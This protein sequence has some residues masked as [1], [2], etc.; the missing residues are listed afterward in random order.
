M[1][2]NT[3]ITELTRVGKTVASRLKRLEIET[4]KDLLFHFPFRYE[5]YS[6]VVPIKELEEGKDVT[7]QGTI[8]MINSRRAHRRRMTITEAIVADETGELRIVWF[9]Q[10]FIKKSLASGNTVSLSGKIKRD[11]LGMQ[12]SAPT[13]E[14]LGK[15]EPTYTGKLLPIYPTTSSITQKQLRFLYKQ[16]EPVIDSLEEWIPERVLNDVAIPSLKEALRLIHYPVSVAKAETGFE[17]MKFAELFLL[18]L[19]VQRVR[20]LMESSAST[21]IPFDE[22]AVKSFVDSLPF[23]LTKDQKVAAWQIIQDMQGEH[24]MNRLVQG[25]VG[26]GKTV[27]AALVA[28]NTVKAGY[29]VA[30]M[31]PTEVLAKQ[32][33]ATFVEMFAETEVSIGLLTGSAVESTSGIGSDVKSVAAKKKRMHAALA[34]GA[35]DMVIGTHAL[36]VDDVSFDRLQ[37]VV[38]DEQHRFGVAQRKRLR[39][40]SGD[41]HT[42][43]HF[44]SMTATPIPRSFALTLYGDLDVSLIKEKPAGRKPVKTYV[45]EPHQ[46]RKAYEFIEKQIV[47]GGQ[48]FVICPLVEDTDDGEKKSV[49]G[50]FERLRK[51]VFPTLKV[52]YVHGKLKPGEKDAAMQAFANGEHDILVSTSVVE[53]GVNVPNATVML[54]EGAERF[55]LSQ[56]HQFR[57][58]VGRGD[59]Q[60]YCMLFT[61]EKG[62][63]VRER[64]TFFASCTDGFKLSEYDFEQ[65]GPG[66][67]Y[68]FNQSGLS[69][70]RVAT[71]FDLALLE[72]AK[73]AAA[74]ISLEEQGKMLA[75]VIGWQDHIHLE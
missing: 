16:I 63:H 59:K 53:V 9:N 61:D 66:S 35:I 68:G 67:M 6:A 14:V 23:E 37:L 30:V 52:G 31:A 15:G 45:V 39:D 28:Y 4:V 1:M 33:F 17:R 7:V 22:G 69:E 46:R 8:Q 29:Q 48:A 21:S 26:A 12:M 64:L 72:Q 24:P 56:L 57:G 20:A 43:P 36:I 44:L 34:E 71:L 41:K 38:V 49:M 73:K 2:L 27:V 10:P 58:R 51:D 50:E 65:R 75:K 74:S 18:Q 70:L 42:S 62:N 40:K 60:A 32:H 13:F 54:I 47:D 3:P 5:D 11:M 19:R 25:D 55:G